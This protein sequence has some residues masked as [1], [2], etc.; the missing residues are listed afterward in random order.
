MNDCVDA[1]RVWVRVAAITFRFREDSR[2]LTRHMIA[3]LFDLSSPPVPYVCFLFDCVVV[4]G[5]KRSIINSVQVCRI[6]I[7]T[8]SVEIQ[9]L[10]DITTANILA[11]DIVVERLIMHFCL[12]P[13]F[14]RVLFKQDAILVPPVHILYRFTTRLLALVV[15]RQLVVNQMNHLL[16]IP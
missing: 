8:E 4:F 11:H 9:R 5:R 3:N 15:R 13:Q 14:L 16:H 7:I 12:L 10:N 2:V 1:G 6:S